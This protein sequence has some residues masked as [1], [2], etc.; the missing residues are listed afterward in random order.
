MILL[1][2]SLSWPNAIVFCV[3]IICIASVFMGKWPWERD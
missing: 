3:V 2:E 1:A